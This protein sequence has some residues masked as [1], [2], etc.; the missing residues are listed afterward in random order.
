MIS[1][2]ESLRL[3]KNHVKNRNLVNHMIAV[4]AIMKSMANHFGKDPTL[5][6]A[7]GMLHDVDYERTSNDFLR[8]GLLS[9][10]IVENFLPEIGLKA[11]R[12]HNPMTGVKAESRMEISLFAA[13]AISGMIVAGALVRP[14]RLEGMKPKS[15]RRRMK[16]KSFARKVNR[17]NIIRCEEIGLDLNTFLALSIEAMQS[18]SDEI[19]L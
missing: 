3:V 13:D 2:K 10:S 1:R 12:A 5:W 18:V 14:T 4:S 6:E 7:V 11:I 15:L 16:D 9:A 8:H 19:G 17:E